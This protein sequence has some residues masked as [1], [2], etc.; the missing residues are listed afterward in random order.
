MNLWQQNFSSPSYPSSD[1]QQPYPHLKNPC[2]STT[3][4]NLRNHHPSE[5]KTQKEQKTERPSLIKLIVMGLAITVSTLPMSEA[6]T[7]HT[8]ISEHKISSKIPETHSEKTI[9]HG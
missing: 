8:S 9:K 2:G 6:K 7:I 4:P 3:E 1:K 5:D